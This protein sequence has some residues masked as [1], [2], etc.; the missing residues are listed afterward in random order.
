MAFNSFLSRDRIMGLGHPVLEGRPL[1]RVGYLWS[2][3]SNS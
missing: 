1:R 2:V 3:S